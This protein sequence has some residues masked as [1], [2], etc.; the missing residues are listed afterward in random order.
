MIESEHYLLGLLLRL[1]RPANLEMVQ[2]LYANGLYSL[3]DPC[4]IA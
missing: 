3:D 4:I 2:V 1:L